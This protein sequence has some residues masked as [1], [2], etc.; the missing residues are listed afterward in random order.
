[1]T[2]LVAGFGYAHTWKLRSL[3]MSWTN[4]MNFSWTGT[5]T[6]NVFAFTLFSYH[7]LFTVVVKANHVM[8]H[9]L[10]DINGLFYN[11]ELYILV[12]IC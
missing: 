9:S 4:M 10:L 12:K 7:L 2:L 5:W 11:Q 3:E 8:N 6:K 1:M